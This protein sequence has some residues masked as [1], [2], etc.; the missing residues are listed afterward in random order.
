MFPT[1]NPRLPPGTPVL[2]RAFGN[3]PPVHTFV[4]AL[5]GAGAAA[6]E[7]YRAKKLPTREFKMLNGAREAETPLARTSREKWQIS[8]RPV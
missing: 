3:V 2:H 6:M 1:G 5:K 7:A 8:D 4:Y